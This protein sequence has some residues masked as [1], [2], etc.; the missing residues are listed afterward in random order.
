M[1]QTRQLV[2]AVKQ[3]I[4]LDVYE[5]HILPALFVL[6]IQLAVAA[7]MTMEKATIVVGT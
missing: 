4:Y 2:C 1:K 7:K 5:W 3:S 6:L